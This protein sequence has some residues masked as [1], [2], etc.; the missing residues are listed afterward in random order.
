MLIEDI[1]ETAYLTWCET[2][3]ALLDQR[4]LPVKMQMISDYGSHKVKT[5]GM[6]EIIS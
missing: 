3:R 1:L 5:W 4:E 6:R 2:P